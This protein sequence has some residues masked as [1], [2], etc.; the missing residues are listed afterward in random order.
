MQVNKA[1]SMDFCTAKARKFFP[2]CGAT[3]R[4]ARH[5]VCKLLDIGLLSHATHASKDGRALQRITKERIKVAY[6]STH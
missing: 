2:N 5:S 6:T 3:E 1:N 4:A